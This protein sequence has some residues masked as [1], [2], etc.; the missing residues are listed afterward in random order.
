MML[1]LVCV[2]GF[3]AGVF[4]GVMLM[5]AFQLGSR[6]DDERGLT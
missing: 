1:V 2:I 5:A 6:C 3:G 4:I